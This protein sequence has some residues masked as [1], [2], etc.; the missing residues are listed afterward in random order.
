MKFD[1]LIFDLD[2]NV[3]RF[4]SGRR[5][6]LE[7]GARR[8]RDRSPRRRPHPDPRRLRI[9]PLLI[10]ALERRGVTDKQPALNRFI[11][12]YLGDCVRGTVLY[13]N[14]AE[15]LSSLAGYKK[16]I[17]TNKST[18]FVGKILA[19][20]GVEDHFSATTARESFAKTK[21]DPLP[22]TSILREYQVAPHRALMIG[23]TETDV[24][25]GTNAGIPTCLV[26]YG[27]GN[28]ERLARRNRRSR[29]RR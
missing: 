17:L 28:V 12:Y 9:Q 27:Y 11:E 15:V 19:N 29:L 5:P 26:T 22:I 1:L 21:P 8:V 16:V 6:G 14:V 24:D 18:R 13:A 20:L 10:E 7:P 23:D 2:G 25:A 3:D 4:A